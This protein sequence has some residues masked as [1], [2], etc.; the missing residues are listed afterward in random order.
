MEKNTEERK[1][2]KITYIDDIEK[3]NQIQKRDQFKNEVTEDI[4][5]V[6]NRVTGGKNKKNKSSKFLNFLIMLGIIILVLTAIN[7]LL[8]NI[9]LLKFFINSFSESIR[10]WLGK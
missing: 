1:K 3:R 9:W 4:G 6:F 7:L 2:G 10:G 8:G 5:D